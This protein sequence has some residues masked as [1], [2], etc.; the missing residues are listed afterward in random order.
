[1]TPATL[2]PESEATGSK[3]TATTRS[4]TYADFQ[5]S[6]IANAEHNEAMIEAALGREARIQRE[7]QIQ[8]EEAEIQAMSHEKPRPS[9]GHPPARARPSSQAPA[10]A[11]AGSPLRPV[12]ACQTLLA[13][14]ACVP[15][16][17][18]GA[19]PDLGS[20]GGVRRCVSARKMRCHLRK[21][22]HI[23]LNVR[24]TPP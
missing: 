2:T 24:S 12:P 9:A 16:R 4:S 23:Y 14:V 3:T 1:M 21:N 17:P 18:K 20:K 7:A 10:R 13:S 8:Q 5:Q 15:W 19:M 22:T 11:E 6:A